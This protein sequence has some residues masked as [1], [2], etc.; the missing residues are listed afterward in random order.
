MNDGMVG[1]DVYFR[2]KYKNGTGPVLMVRVWSAVVFLA[3][4][5]ARGYVQK[6]AEVPSTREEYRRDHWK[7]AA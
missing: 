4:E 5:N 2:R 1:T 3:A 6:A 7:K